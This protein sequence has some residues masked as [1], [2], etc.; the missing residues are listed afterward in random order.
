MK[1]RHTLILVITIIMLSGVY[2]GYKLLSTTKN[3]YDVEIKIP[4]NS[5]TREI[6]NILHEKSIIRSKYYFIFEQKVLHKDKII[7]FGTF[8][9]PKQIPLSRLANI[10]AR[11]GKDANMIKITIPEGYNTEQ[12]G[13]LL[14]KN[15]LVTKNDF[16]N[17]VANWKDTSYWFLKDIPQDT[18]ML[19]GFLFPNTYFFYKNETSDEIIHAMLDQFDKEISQYKNYIIQSNYDIRN[20]VIVASLIEKEARK[21]VDRPKIASVIYNRLNKDM[22]LQIDATIIYVIGHKDKLYNKDLMV[23]SPYNTYINKGLPPSSICNP[24]IASITAA[25]H[26]EKTDYLY[27]VLNEQTSEHVF[28]KTYQEHVENI[29]KYIKH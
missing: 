12:I 23:Q 2:Y 22:P 21:D 26:P 19:D 13:Q 1:I 5:S 29:K 16:L 20:L 15:G 4:E 8:I 3:T 25:I 28:A 10:L 14:E 9:I 11:Y 6:A 7:K 24:G 17:K 18:H 27:Y